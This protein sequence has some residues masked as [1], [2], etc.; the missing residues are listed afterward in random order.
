MKTSA[1]AIPGY[2]LSLSL[3]PEV[4]ARS[5]PVPAPGAR[6]GQQHPAGASASGAFPRDAPFPFLSLPSQQALP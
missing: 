5:Q 1:E 3:Q 4:S 2:G 6:G